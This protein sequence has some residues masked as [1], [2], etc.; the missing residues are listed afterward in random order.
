[1][2]QRITVAIA[3]LAVVLVPLALAGSG[4][5]EPA[6][7]R[8]GGVASHPP[9]EEGRSY[10]FAYEFSGDIRKLHHDSP[11]SVE[12]EYLGEQRGSWVKV[13]QTRADQPSEKP[14]VFWVN[15][16]RV[17]IVKAWP[18]VGE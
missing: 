9:L 11:N 13:R 14:T 18:R 8:P 12:G 2:K 4:K 10:F 3:V 5:R 16:D 15:L 1:M 17:A 6:V 7:D